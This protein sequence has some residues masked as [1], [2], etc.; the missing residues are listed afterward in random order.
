MLALAAPAAAQPPEDTVGTGVGDAGILA[1]IT[2]DDVFAVTDL[3]LVLPLSFGGSSPR[4]YGPY[5]GTSPDSG[6]CGND[7]ATDFFDRVFTVRQ[8]GT[9]SY[10]VVEQFK[11][12]TFETIAGPSPGACQDALPP[13]GNGHVVD[14]DTHGK[15]HG[16]FVIPVTSAVFNPDECEPDPN[17]AEF[18][19][20]HFPGGTAGDINTFFFHYSGNDG[21]NKDLIYHEWKNASANRGGNHGDIAVA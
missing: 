11:N 6:T 18:L 1:L 12:G 15:M 17:T 20:C 4:K 3:A 2:D 13:L 5:D 8:E 16:Y 7:W 14:S 10:T 9:N 21:E 19:L